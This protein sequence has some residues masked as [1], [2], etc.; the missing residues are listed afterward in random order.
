MI[1]LRNQYI[2]KYIGVQLDNVPM[3]DSDW[4]KWLQADLIGTVVI[5]D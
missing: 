5:F 4:F 2:T 3:A 1:L